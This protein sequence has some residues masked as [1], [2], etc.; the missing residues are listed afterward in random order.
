MI[1][2]LPIILFTSLLSVQALADMV[3]I[4]ADRD[5]TLIEDPDGALSNG[6]GPNF[7]AGRTNQAMNSIRRG[8]VRFDVASAVPADAIIDRVFLTLY[9]NSNNFAPSDVSLHRVLADWGEG[10]SF[11]AGGGGAQA[12]PGDATWQHTFYDYDFWVQPGGQ[13]VPYASA[14][15]T[16]L[17]NDLYTWQ[18]TVQMVNNVRLWLKNPERNFGWLIM[19]DESTGGTA[20][21]FDSR[22]SG[23]PPM[24][25]IEYHLQGN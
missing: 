18:S 7:R 25:T 13:F 21:R 3:H 11:T 2:L 12:E 19:G 6:I 22:E 1:K 10:D 23:Q 8:L 15:E 9:Q 16:V 5:N 20:K 17:G 4:P 24:L 14:T